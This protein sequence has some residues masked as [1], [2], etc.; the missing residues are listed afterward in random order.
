[1]EPSDVRVQALD[2]PHAATA[3]ESIIILAIPSPRRALPFILALVSKVSLWHE[4][5]KSKQVPHAAQQIHRLLLVLSERPGMRFNAFL[6]VAVGVG[7]PPR[8][9]F[10]PIAA[11]GF[12]PLRGKIAGNGFVFLAVCV[13]PENLNLPAVLWCCLDGLPVS[14]AH[15]SSCARTS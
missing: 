7:P 14:H 8:I 13:D 1:M 5:R 15:V 4:P 3:I 2:S 9:T 10:I 6:G 11:G 12:Q